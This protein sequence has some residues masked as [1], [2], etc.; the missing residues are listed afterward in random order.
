MLLSKVLFKQLG[1]LGAFE[2]FLSSYALSN[3]LIA[4]LI[5]Q[6]VLPVIF[7]KQEICKVQFIQ[8]EK[9]DF[10]LCEAKVP[11]AK[12][13]FEEIQTQNEESVERLFIRFM[14]HLLE[15]DFENKVIS[16]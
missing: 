9:F 11:I 15:F 1:I 12:V 6:K 2:G 13:D 10:I 8:R 14:L 7:E 16:I 5:D 4:F 3:I